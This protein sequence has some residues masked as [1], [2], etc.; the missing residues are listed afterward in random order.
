M[1]IE[2]SGV[3]A[4]VLFGGERVQITTYRLDLGGDRHGVARFGPFEQQ[5]F[6]EVR[7]AHL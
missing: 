2:Y 6:E 7:R 4:G 3:V 5:V 1:L